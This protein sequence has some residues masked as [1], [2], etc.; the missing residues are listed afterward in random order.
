MMSKSDIMKQ[1]ALNNNLSTIDIKMS[2]TAFDPVYNTNPC[3][4]I[5]GTQ[6]DDLVHL[7]DFEAM[8]WGTPDKKC[9]CGAKYTSRPDYHLDWCPLYKKPKE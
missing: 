2:R 7:T 1:Y 6:I 8:I 4:Q 3:S 5:S 9:E